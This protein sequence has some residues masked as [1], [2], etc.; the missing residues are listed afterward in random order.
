MPHFHQ[1]VT[2]ALKKLKYAKSFT[3]QVKIVTAQ[4]GVAQFEL[5]LEK[6]HCD[7]Q[8]TMHNGTAFTLIDLYTWATAC[9]LYDEG[10]SFTSLN[11]EARFLAPAALGSEIFIDSRAADPGG[12]TAF[13]E[14]DILDK[15]TQQILVQG[16][17]TMFMLSSRV[18]VMMAQQG[19]A[20]FELWLEKEH[21]NLQGT[22][23]NGTALCTMARHSP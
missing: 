8:G 13:V 23:H 2:N 14:M 17:H 22:M 21:C 12:R 7:L 4:K 20:Q 10:T 9:T 6:E 1:I 3:D 15:T 11:I 19:A 16:T 18:K 5:R